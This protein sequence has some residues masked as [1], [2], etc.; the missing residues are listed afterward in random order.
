MRAKMNH[1]S[2][3]DGYGVAIIGAGPYG[4]SIAAHLRQRGIP[5]RI[6]GTPMRSWTREMPKDMRLKSEGF[7]SNLSDPTGRHTLKQFCTDQGLPYADMGLPT[8]RETLARYGLAFRAALVP[9]VEERE[10]RALDRQGDGFRLEL[11]DGEIVFASTV[12]VAVGLTYFQWI[13]EQLRGLGPFVSHSAAHYDLD[14][15]RGRQVAVIGGGASAVDLAGLLNEAGAH[16]QLFVRGNRLEIH[17]E[18]SSSRSLLDRVN[19]PFSGIGPGWRNLMFTE[20]P[21]IYHYFPEETRHRIAMKTV[22][23]AGC[24]FMRD[25]V[26]GRLPIHLNHTIAQAQAVGSRIELRFGT[27]SGKEHIDTFDHVIAATGYRYNLRRIAFLSNA[28]QEQLR[29][30]FGTPILDSD[31]QSS[32]PGLH[33]VGAISLNS[34]GPVVRFIYGTRF[35]AHRLAAALAVERRRF[36][37]NGPNR[38]AGAAS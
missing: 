6:F 36:S 26:E 24:W 5:F 15:F 29:S 10:V 11:D 9:E 3:T 17:K 35:T 16:V 23:P 14:G 31:F 1:E 28:L 30:R 32:V 25:R 22:G 4:L 19:A 21:N 18:G 38:L 7:A 13:P 34:F 2:A 27:T 12:V 8:P 37:S 20:F 33:F